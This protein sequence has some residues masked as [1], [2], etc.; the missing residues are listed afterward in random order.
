LVPQEVEKDT[1]NAPSEIHTIV[2][3]LGGVIAA[4]GH[5]IIMMKISRYYESIPLESEDLRSLYTIEKMV[6][7]LAFFGTNIESFSLSDS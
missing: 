4:E 5:L 3:L 6:S 7:W 2:I 1:I